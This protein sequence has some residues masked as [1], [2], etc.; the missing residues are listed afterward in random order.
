[1]LHIKRWLLVLL[2]ALLFAACGKQPAPVAVGVTAPAV[3]TIWKTVC[4]CRSG[5]RSATACD[6]Q[7]Q[8]GFTQL[9]NVQGGMIVWGQASYAIERP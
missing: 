7:A 4:I 8:Q 3:A 1:M 2:G 9:R 5:N 6:L